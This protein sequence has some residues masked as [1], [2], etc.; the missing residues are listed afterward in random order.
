MANRNDWYRNT[1][2]NDK[3]EREFFAK[4]KRAR[5]QRDQY[6][7]IQSLSLAESVPDVAI[8]LT[9]HYFETRTKHSNDARVYSARAKA[10]RSQDRVDEAIDAYVA[11]IDEERK[12]HQFPTGSDLELPY[13]IAVKEVADRYQ[14]AVSLLK[15][16]QGGSVW[17]IAVFKWN[18][19]MALIT[20]RSVQSEQAI[21]YA[22][23]ALDAASIRNTE[24]TYHREL[25]LVDETFNPVIDKLKNIVG[26]RRF[27]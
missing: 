20:H 18:A 19:A 2:W 7:A 6:L 4:L 21:E 11:A 15:D 17:P 3:I 25:G 16:I 5:S 8:R 12:S 1:T 23:G 24:L 26:G 27:Q 10:L 22:I 9:Y 14:L 13:Y